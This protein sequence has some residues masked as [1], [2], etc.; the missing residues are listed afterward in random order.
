MDW[1]EVA[2]AFVGGVILINLTG[3]AVMLIVSPF[4]HTSR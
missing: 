3:F 2:A 4:M 1:N